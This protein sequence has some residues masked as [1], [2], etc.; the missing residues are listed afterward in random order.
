MERGAFWLPAEPPTHREDGPGHGPDNPPNRPGARTTKS[1]IHHGDG[2]L[3]APHVAHLAERGEHGEHGECLEV[4]VHDVALGPHQALHRHSRRHALMERKRAET[5]ST[6]RGSAVGVGAVGMR[7]W[8]RSGGGRKRTARLVRTSPIGK[9][10]ATCIIR[11]ERSMVS[12]TVVRTRTPRTMQIRTLNVLMA[13][14]FMAA[15]LPTRAQSVE[16]GAP[17]PAT[18]SKA[19]MKEVVQRFR[20]LARKGEFETTP[21]Y[22]ERVRSEAG[23]ML[24]SLVLFEVDANC[25]HIYWLYN[26][27]AEEFSFKWYFQI[28]SGFSLFVK[29]GIDVGGSDV[30][31]EKKNIGRFQGA[32]ALGVKFAYQAY[33]DTTYGVMWTPGKPTAYSAESQFKMAIAEAQ[34]AKPYLR[35]YLLGRLAMSPTLGLTAS[36]TTARSA[37]VSLPIESYGVSYYAWITDVTVAVV[38][39]RTRTV[40]WVMKVPTGEIP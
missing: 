28:P 2:V 6:G 20:A 10:G 15:S 22:A 24:D 21:K 14:A 31:C 37:T 25:T 34:A 18:I 33:R 13:L 12:L 5:T 26:A 27:D 3:P 1:A 17:L 9:S 16:V 29:S 40:L 35:G 19:S 4:A 30:T 8:S 32:T 39:S 36:N 7:S 11:L 38:D 23:T